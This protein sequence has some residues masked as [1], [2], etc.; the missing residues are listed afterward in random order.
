MP[1]PQNH[2]YP[3]PHPQ[4]FLKPNPNLEKSNVLSQPHSKKSK[5]PTSSK[6]LE[7]KIKHP[8]KKYKSHNL[9][10]PKE[11]TDSPSPKNRCEF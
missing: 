6:K 11:D 2:I 5:T 1:K 8:K 3:K 4:N 7:K 10:T 9:P